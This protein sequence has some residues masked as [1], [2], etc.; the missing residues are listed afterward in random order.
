MHNKMVITA[1]HSNSLARPIAYFSRKAFV[2][3]DLPVLYPDLPTPN[4]IFCAIAGI[5]SPS[6]LRSRA[7]RR[8]GRQHLRIVLVLVELEDRL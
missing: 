5:L 2:F 8:S 4:F 1:H 6:F 7:R 3:A